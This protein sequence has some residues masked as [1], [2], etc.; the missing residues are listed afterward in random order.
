MQRTFTMVLVGL[1]FSACATARHRGES[2]EFVPE[3]EFEIAPGAMVEIDLDVP[4]STIVAAVP[5]DP[6]EVAFEASGPI[7]WNIHVHDGDKVEV[8]QQGND[9]AGV[10]L[11]TPSR[12]GPVSLM[13]ENKGGTALT[14]TIRIDGLPAG[15]TA[16]WSRK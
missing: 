11:Y 5:V 13:W 14:T 4:A 10:L 7:A 1:L 8:L 2:S 6:V 9:L 3:R 16:R 15:T 12:P